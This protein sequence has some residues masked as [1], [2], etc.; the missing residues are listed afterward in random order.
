MSLFL[1]SATDEF[2]LSGPDRKIQAKIYAYSAWVAVF[3]Q[4][5]VGR[6]MIVLLLLRKK[7]TA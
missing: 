5:L 1:V 3:S 7:L 4:I 6:L 2:K